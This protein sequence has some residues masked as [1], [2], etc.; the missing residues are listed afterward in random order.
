M[1]I[2]LLGCLVGRIWVWSSLGEQWNV[3]IMATQRPIVDT[4]P[5]R[6]VRHPNY[7]IVIGEMLAI[8]LV[9]TAYI[10]ALC[11]SFANAFVLQKRIQ[12]EEAALSVRTDY[13]EKMRAKP[14]FL[15]LSLRGQ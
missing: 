5:Y 15:P 12:Q 9:H 3:Q 2:L 10:T 13:A 14:R 7:T 8:P 6:Y 1:F 4:G 11:C